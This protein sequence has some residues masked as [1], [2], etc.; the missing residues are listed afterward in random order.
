MI[1]IFYINL[2]SQP[3]RNTWFAEQCRNLGL[4][5]VRVA[6]VC[7]RTMPDADLD[8]IRQ[9]RRLDVHFGAAEIGCFFSHCRAWDQFLETGSEWGFIAEDDIHLAS[10]SV[11]FFESLH[12]IPE[13]A[14]LIKAETTFKKCHLGRPLDVPGNTRKLHPLLSLHGGG[15]GY[16]ISRNSATILRQCADTIA[17]PPDLLVFDPRLGFFST[18]KVYQ[19][20]P[21]IAVQD[22]FIPDRIGKFQTSVEEPEPEAFRRK[23]VAAKLVRELKRPARQLGHYIATLMRRLIWRTEWRA[24]PYLTSPGAK[25]RILRKRFR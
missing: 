10:D 23:R 25:P 7:G 24:V 16:F 13:G 19:I 22:R 5:V 15:G 6:A 9:R 18:Q 4:D 12:W 3:E 2:D 1:P 11:H 20:D 21:A 8:S 14:D 17:E